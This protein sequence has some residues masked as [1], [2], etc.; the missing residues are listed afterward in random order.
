MDFQHSGK[1]PYKDIPE[2]LERHNLRL[3]ILVE[4]FPAEQENSIGF[5][6]DA[7][8]A[9]EFPTQPAAIVV[10]LIK[11]LVDLGNSLGLQITALEL[12]QTDESPN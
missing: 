5:F 10:E 9:R 11:I 4:N 8:W 7:K 3:A 1:N 2:I 6:F 12:P